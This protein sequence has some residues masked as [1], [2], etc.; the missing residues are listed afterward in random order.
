MHPAP[1]HTWE[2]L[3]LWSH[4][5]HGTPHKGLRSWVL[6][7]WGAV[8]WCELPLTRCPILVITSPQAGNTDI[9]PNVSLSPGLVSGLRPG[10][11]DNGAQ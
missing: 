8:D 5:P 10:C 2:E 1:Q 4:S 7:S 6:G 3:T 9:I 11:G